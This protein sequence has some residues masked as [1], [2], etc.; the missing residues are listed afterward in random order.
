MDAPHVPHG[1][2]N[3]YIFETTTR[4]LF[5]GDLLTQPGAEC[6]AVTT[7]DVLG[8]SE[9][10]RA[11]LDYFAHSP[12]TRAAIARL[13]ATGP[14]LLACMHGSAF[15]GDGARVLLDLAD[16][17]ESFPPA[18]AGSSTPRASA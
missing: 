10:M 9:A 16:A 13:A 11:R 8:S 18:G 4:T 12:N 3:G 7:N 2:E 5:C 14:R 1:W 17:L 15:S 6:P